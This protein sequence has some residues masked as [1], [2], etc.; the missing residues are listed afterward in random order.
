MVGPTVRIESYDLVTRLT[1]KRYAS[2]SAAA[3]DTGA[4]VP[5]INKCLEG[6]KTEA[7]GVGWRLRP[8]NDGGVNGLIVELPPSL[9]AP[10]GAPF[11][12]A[13]VPVPVPVPA[14]AP[15]LP[16][17]APSAAAVPAVPL[18]VPVPVLALAPAPAPS[19]A[20]AAV[21][22]VAVAL[23]PDGGIGTFEGSD[24]GAGA[25]EAYDLGT[26]QTLAWYPSRGAAVKETRAYRQGINECLEGTRMECGGLGWRWAR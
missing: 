8:P 19:Q 6:K 17:P 13:P 16:P 12:P 26:R 10:V 3:R 5:A 21:G 1:V 4:N 18:L 15:P 20:P 11:V 22:M 23:V 7:A 24:G 14:P 2:K 25:I 9:A